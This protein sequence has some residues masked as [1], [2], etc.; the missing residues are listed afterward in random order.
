MSAEEYL[1]REERAQV[2]HEYVAGHVYAMTGAT[3][4]HN[5][6]VR[7]VFAALHSAAGAGPCEVTVNDIK[8]NVQNDTF[9]YPDVVVTCTP[10]DDEALYVHEPCLIVEVTSLSTRATDRREKLL[11]Y[12]RLPSLQAYLIVDHRR[13]RVWSYVPD[14]SDNGLRLRDEITGDGAVSVPCPQ[15]TLTLA[16]IYA[17]V[18]VPAVG[19]RAR[20]RYGASAGG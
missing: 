20:A 15:T 11:G 8:V 7:N 17:G 16:A 3:M 1:R 19:E 4:R 18:T 2:K 9:Y 6:I 13:R 14:P 12:G 10:V 5:R